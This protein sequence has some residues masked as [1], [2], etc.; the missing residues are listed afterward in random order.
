M[1]LL[2]SAATILKRALSSEVWM[3]TLTLPDDALGFPARAS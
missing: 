3:L 1:S 2:T